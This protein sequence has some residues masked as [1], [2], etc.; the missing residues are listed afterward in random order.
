M[1]CKPS[2]YVIPLVAK[3]VEDTKRDIKRKIKPPHNHISQR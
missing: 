2:D 3:T 1:Q